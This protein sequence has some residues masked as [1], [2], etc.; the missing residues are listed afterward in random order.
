MWAPGA[1]TECGKSPNLQEFGAELPGDH[2]E[3]DLE[4]TL[5]VLQDRE[6]FI[7][8]ENDGIP[9]VLLHGP[10]KDMRRIQRIP[11]RSPEFGDDTC[12][13]AY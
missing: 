7:F 8:E 4:Q 5:G 6:P 11:P 3:R 12:D 13:R 9:A 1:P 10:N 2:R